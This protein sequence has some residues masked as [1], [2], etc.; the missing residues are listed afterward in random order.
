MA[1]PFPS[2]EGR[3]SRSMIEGRWE[4]AKGRVARWSL[5]VCR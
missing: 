2:L 5:V 1:D 3:F 4:R